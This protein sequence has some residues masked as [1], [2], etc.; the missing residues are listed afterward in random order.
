MRSRLTTVDSS[1]SVGP[2]DCGP[3][4]MHKPRRAESLAC[5]AH[6]TAL[7]LWVQGA[8]ARVQKND[9]ENNAAARGMAWGMA[10]GAAGRAC[11]IPAVA[12]AITSSAWQPVAHL[13]L[14][15]LRQ[16]NV[17]QLGA[18][19]R[20]ARKRDAHVPMRVA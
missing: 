13:H 5:R 7:G 3:T 19:A 11:R 6:S 14:C 16:R 12:Q 18:R 4:C 17:C 15:Q 10:A 1:A 8:K 2:C 9:T 20:V